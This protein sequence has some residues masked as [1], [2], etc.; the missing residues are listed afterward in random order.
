MGAS[1][2]LILASLAV[3]VFAVCLLE[4][5]ARRSP[6]R[7]M[8]MDMMQ[9]MMSFW[10]NGMTEMFKASVSMFMTS[11]SAM[12]GPM[13]LYE[14]AV[15]YNVSCNVCKCNN[16]CF[17]GVDQSMCSAIWDSISCT[18]QHKPVYKGLCNKYILISEIAKGRSVSHV[19][20]SVCPDSS[21]TSSEAIAYTSCN[22]T[23]SDSW[24]PSAHN[25]MLNCNN[26]YR[27]IAMFIGNKYVPGSA[28][29]FVGCLT[30]SEQG[31]KMVHQSCGGVPTII[32]VSHTEQR[33]N[34]PERFYF[35]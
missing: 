3:C 28:G 17:N 34:D 6:K 15:L 18:D 25:A 20:A 11:M 14:G 27:P 10:W 21:H 23:Q 26:T 5:N 12:W 2:T 31:F 33:W 24:V 1:K 8:F 29:V 32:H 35:V 7:F 13:T 19:N 9:S 4:A 16:T 30:G 22:V